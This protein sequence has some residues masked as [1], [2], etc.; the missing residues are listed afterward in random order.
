MQTPH[1]KARDN[2][3]SN[4]EPS[5][6]EATVLSTRPP[7]LH[8]PPCL[9]RMNK[10]RGHKSIPTY[11][12]TTTQLGKRDCS[13]DSTEMNVSTTQPKLNEGHEQPQQG[14]STTNSPEPVDHVAFY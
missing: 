10:D 12:E 13:C 9:P 6:C 7:C 2:R 14:T 5:C 1:R 3:G 11:P 8:G 4:P